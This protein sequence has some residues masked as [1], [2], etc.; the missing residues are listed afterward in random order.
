MP[1]SGRRIEAI[2]IRPRDELTGDAVEFRVFAA[3]DRATPWVS[4]GNY[5]G[6][7]GRELALIGFAARPAPHIAERFDVVYE[8]WFAEGG[9]V[10]PLRNGESC[11]SP[12]PDDPIEALRV[13]FIERRDEPAPPITE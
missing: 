2:S 5:A 13:G 6:T 9:A 8:G 12:V 4:D 3:A 7:S 10:G 11:L 1:G